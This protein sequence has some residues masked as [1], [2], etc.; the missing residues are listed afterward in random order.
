MQWNSQICDARMCTCCTIS[1]C[2]TGQYD[3]KVIL[4]NLIYC[5]ITNTCNFFTHSRNSRKQF[6]SLPRPSFHGRS[7]Y[8][9]RLNKGREAKVHLYEHQDEFVLVW[10]SSQDKKDHFNKGFTLGTW[11][12]SECHLAWDKLIHHGIKFSPP[13]PSVSWSFVLVETVYT[14]W[15]LGPGRA[16]PAPKPCK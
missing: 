16:H 9:L 12:E 5:I 11:D 15:F 13:A 10:K 14:E 1:V 4:K 8:I 2:Y 7:V 3:W 6:Y